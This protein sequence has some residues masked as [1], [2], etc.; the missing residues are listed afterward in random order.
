MPGPGGSRKRLLIAVAAVAAM[1]LVAVAWYVKANDEG[2]P[3]SVPSCTWPLRVRGP[4]TS[5]QAG[6]VRCYLRALA[7]HD[8]G[9][10]LAVA[11]MSGLPI[12]IT[13][14]DFAHAADARAGRATATFTP[15]SADDADMGVAIFFA[16]GARETVDMHVAN[17]SS[18]HSWRL[19]IG[20]TVG[21]VPPAVNRASP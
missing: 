17:P 5:E 7:A 16:D 14:A 12:R 3:T 8:A 15:N 13:R 10:L 11:D 1:L 19:E 2:L 18:A 6:L 9:G 4:A 21:P 20:S